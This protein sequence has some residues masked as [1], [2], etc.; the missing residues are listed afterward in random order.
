MAVKDIGDNARRLMKIRG[1][2]VPALA[3]RGGIGTA[4]L[5][6]VL[7]GKS[8]PK[9]STLIALA[10]ALW[11]TCGGPDCRCSRAQVTTI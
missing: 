11:C 1:L 8:E 4:T 3:K 9:S 6:N 10:K 7:N 2:T 5:S